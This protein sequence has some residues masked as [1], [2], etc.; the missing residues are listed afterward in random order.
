M[1]CTAK[2]RLVGLKGLGLGIRLATY[3]LGLDSSILQVLLKVQAFVLHL[4]VITSVKRMELFPFM[5][6]MCCRNQD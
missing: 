2:L 3:G 1:L 5:I 4:H 6:P